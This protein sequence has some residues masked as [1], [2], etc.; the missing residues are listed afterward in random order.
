MY[1]A[2]PEVEFL[3]NLR[4]D[5]NGVQG[6]HIVSWYTDNSLVGLPDGRVNCDPERLNRQDI[7]S[8]YS[9]R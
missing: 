6:D 3:G 2:V 1:E 7:K 5:C 8:N 4:L 9:S